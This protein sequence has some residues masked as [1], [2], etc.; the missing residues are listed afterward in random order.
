MNRARLVRRGH[1][2]AQLPAA[3]PA[4]PAAAH[5]LE[6]LSQLVG[7]R[8]VARMLAR[9]AIDAPIVKDR[10]KI[11]ELAKKKDVD[12]ADRL[13]VYAEIA[14]TQAVQMDP[15][16][17]YKSTY[18]QDGVNL[19]AFKQAGENPAQAGF[20]DG[21]SKK[22]SGGAPPENASGVAIV[23]NSAAGRFED[24][25]YMVA[26]IRHE[27]VHARLMR[28]TLKHRAD[29]QKD[30]RG[31]SFAQYV[32]QK[33]GGS[34]GALIRDRF[35]GG[36]M[37]ETLAYAEGFL[38]AF[39]YTPISEPGKDDPAWVAHLKGFAKEF[40]HSNLNAGPVRKTGTGIEESQIAM[41]Q[42]AGAAMAEAEKLVKEYCDAGGEAKRKN[43]GAWM[44]WL[45]ERG[46]MYQPAL[47]MIYKAATGKAM[48][49][50]KR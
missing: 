5:E 45:S 33:V 13:R 44:E 49:K 4:P 41:R 48:P 11:D 30:P 40:H 9:K 3:A 7:N 12:P 14:G 28:L 36:H 25:D 23:V 31:R 2:G 18:Y 19:D 35:F 34:D 1:S 8:A 42:S 21:S 27:M 15:K 37:D 46:A 47:D 24:E 43:L 29:W 39:L 17:V 50:R 38:S 16:K 20:I 22:F 10:T 6:R 32:D 26:A